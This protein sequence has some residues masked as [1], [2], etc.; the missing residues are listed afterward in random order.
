[1][2][3][4]QP[5]KTLTRRR[6]VVATLAAAVVGGIAY[7]SWPAPLTVEEQK[8]VGLWTFPMG[9]NPPPNAAQQFFELR[10]DHSL[11]TWRRAIASG[12]KSEPSAGYWKLEGDSL[13]FEHATRDYWTRL[14]RS[15]NGGR[16]PQR[17]FVDRMTYLDAGADA[18]RVAGS[19]GGVVTFERA[20]TPGAGD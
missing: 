16:R 3:T 13:V 2:S 20:V 14:A 7:W 8:L 18:F 15:L 9:P 6:F 4:P 1:M 5:S 17:T 12:V 11:I 10:P 19:N